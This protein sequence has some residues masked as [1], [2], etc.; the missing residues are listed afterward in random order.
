M[1]LQALRSSS[2]WLSAGL[3]AAIAAFALVM[4]A[5]TTF[6][7]Y[8]GAA[9]ALLLLVG[10]LSVSR[11]LAEVPEDERIRYPYHVRQRGRR[12]AWVSLLAGL[13]LG[14]FALWGDVAGISAALGPR[15]AILVAAAA[16]LGIPTTV[17]VVV[18]T[19]D[20]ISLRT[21]LEQPGD[22]LV[23]AAASLTLALALAFV[24]AVTQ[25][26]TSFAVLVAFGGLVP[27]A[28]ALWSLVRIG[29]ALGAARPAA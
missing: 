9:S 27:A 23:G 5:W 22:P 8:A 4:F 24:S 25:W 14:A 6:A 28:F 16:F 29:D 13:G 3:L 26:S 2:R 21:G 10:G 15:L 1:T 19:V 18:W 20:G 17:L 7:V 11:A 12:L